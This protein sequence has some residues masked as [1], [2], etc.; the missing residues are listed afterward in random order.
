MPRYQCIDTPSKPMEQDKLDRWY[1]KSFAYIADV[2]SEE[3]AWAL[4]SERFLNENPHRS[5]LC[6]D[7]FVSLRAL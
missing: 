3:H 2:D 7:C 6:G 4:F 1:D 5:S